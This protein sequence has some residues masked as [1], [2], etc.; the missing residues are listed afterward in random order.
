MYGDRTKQGQ[1]IL[2][3]GVSPLV[4]CLSIGRGVKKIYWWNGLRVHKRKCRF[5]TKGTV[6]IFRNQTR[7]ESCF[8][9]P[10]LQPDKSLE[11]MKIVVVGLPLLNF[12]LWI[13]LGEGIGF[14][15]NTQDSDVVAEL[16]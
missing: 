11:E 7:Q 4:V 8:A 16:W 14:R 3:T 15:T 5:H 2:A 9:L 13:H 6:E 10:I 12:W 1:S